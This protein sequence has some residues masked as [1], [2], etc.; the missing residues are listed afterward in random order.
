MITILSPALGYHLLTMS[1]HCCHAITH[2]QY[3]HVAHQS[4]TFPCRPFC[5]NNNLQGRLKLYTMSCFSL[6]AVSSVM[7]QLTAFVTFSWKIRQDTNHSNCCFLT[8][9]FLPF[10]FLPLPFPFILPLFI[11]LLFSPFFSYPLFALSSL[12]PVSRS[13]GTTFATIQSSLKNELS[14]SCKS[15][16]NPFSALKKRSEASLWIN[17]E[18]VNFNFLATMQIDVRPINASSFPS[19]PSTF[20]VSFGKITG[21]WL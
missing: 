7:P 17:K 3:K 9:S 16:F 8:F 11:F 18:R 13:K 1:T 21:K 6:G 19:S 2:F 12:L 14:L 5:W 10:S 20:K 15:K 4:Y